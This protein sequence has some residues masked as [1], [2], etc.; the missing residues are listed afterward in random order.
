MAIRPILRNFMA[1]DDRE[2]VGFRVL[3]YN[4]DKRFDLAAL[5][6]EFFTYSAGYL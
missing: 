1:I 2:R 4:L 5:G 6:M 3:V